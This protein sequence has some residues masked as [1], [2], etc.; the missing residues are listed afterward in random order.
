M[1][2][3]MKSLALIII[4]S[5]LLIPM[6]MNSAQAAGL[7]IITHTEADYNQMLLTVYGMNFG[8]SQPTVKLGETSLFVQTWGQQQIVA[9]L[10]VGVVSGSYLLTVTVPTRLIPLIAAL[11][12][13]LGADGEPGP[14]GPTGP[15]GPQGIQ[16]ASG[17]VGSSGATGATGPIGPQGAVGPAGPQG[18]AGVIPEELKGIICRDITRSNIDPCPTFCDCTRKVFVSSETYTGMMRQIDPW[19]WGLDAADAK[20]QRLATA[21]GLVGTYKAW[22]S[23]G[24]ASP[25]SRFVRSIYPYVRVDGVMIASNWDDLVDGVLNNPINK[26]ETGVPP[27]SQ[28]Q[29]VWT[30]LWTNGVGIDHNTCQ[31]RRDLY[32]CCGGWYYDNTDPDYEQYYSRFSTGLVQGNYTSMD[33][34]WT[35]ALYNG[36]DCE[37]HPDNCSPSIP[38]PLT[39]DMR[40]HIYC[41]QQ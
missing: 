10:P 13:T 30:G 29:G 21:A 6:V 25:A 2:R 28:T 19:L 14:A 4:V 38:P 32:N 31:A 5:A 35:Y 12:I 16:G 41:F 3:C 26:T 34:N 20:C 15:P 9:Q 40:A 33:S 37:F 22:L 11:S 39:C 24:S 1:R 7:P 27:T 17:P 36:W 23:N 18:P 8:T